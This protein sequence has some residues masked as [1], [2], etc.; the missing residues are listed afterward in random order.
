MDFQIGR[1]ISSFSV[2]NVFPGHLLLSSFPARD[3]VNPG[4]SN[5]CRIYTNYVPTYYNN[6]SSTF[7]KKTEKSEPAQDETIGGGA[8]LPENSAQEKDS[9]VEQPSK[10]TSEK[11][12][13]TKELNKDLIKKMDK[14]VA[15]S[16]MHPKFVKT[17]KIV[18][19]QK[20]QSAEKRLENVKRPKFEGTSL[21]SSSVPKHKF[22]FV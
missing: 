10:P 5:H 7:V 4:L 9:S 21:K 11:D 16:F 8:S 13:L 17:G 6:N 22:Q 15:S 1:K 12:I 20:R 3:Y 19:N 18:F 2:P 14:E